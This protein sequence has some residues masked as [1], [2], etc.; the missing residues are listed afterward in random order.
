MDE[1]L[2]AELLEPVLGAADQEDEDL[3]EAVNLSA[4][5]LAALGAVVLDPDGQPARGVSDERAIVAALNTHAHNLMQAGR[6]DDV[7]EALQVAERIGK[8]ARLPHHPRTV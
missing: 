7:V 4:E 6:L 2:L 5:A 3:S 8:L 1:T